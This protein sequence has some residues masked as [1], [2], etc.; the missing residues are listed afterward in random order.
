M[1]RN[2][3]IIRGAIIVLAFV[4]LIGAI[5][6]RWLTRSRDDPILLVTKWLLTVPLVALCL[7]SIPIA[8]PF[9]P[10]IV[11]FCGIIL[12]L[13]WT[14]NIVGWMI[15]PITSL[16]DG[17]DV[18]PERRPAYSIAR[19][20]R[21]KGQYLEAI[22]EV[23]KQL[24][25][26][27]ND[28]EGAMLLAAIHAEN[29]G[30]LTGAEAILNRFCEEPKRPDRQVAAAMNQIADWHLHFSKNGEAARHALEKIRERF[31]DTEYALMAAQRIAHLATP[32][33]LLAAHDRKKVRVPH[34]VE[35]LGLEKDLSRFKPPEPDWQKRAEDFVKHLEQ[36]PLD[37]EAREKLAV[38]YAEHFGR[39]DLAT[40][41]LQQLIQLRANSPQHVAHWLNLLADLQVK[42][43]L[44]YDTVRATLLTIADLH[45]QSSVAEV[46]RNR[47]DRLRLEFKA[48]EKSQAVALGSYEQRLGLKMKR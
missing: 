34:T 7:M 37:M 19:T 31:P 43:G 44:D 9:A 3:E 42:G 46:A 16:F 36:H 25:E 27:P 21:N 40:D 24:D 38:F 41:Q 8:G 29:L 4:L 14:P 35:Y 22:A 2:Y 33:H 48:K 23:Q 30:D 13:L 11:V 1:N 39:L 10:F 45:P 26:F 47:I 5:L 12:S 17:G 15:R 20:K 6:F 28:L 32:E 18:E